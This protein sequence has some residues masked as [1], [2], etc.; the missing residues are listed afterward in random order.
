MSKP[1]IIFTDG[2][3][4]GNPGPGGWGAVLVSPLGKVK[5]LG[6]AEKQTTNNRMEMTAALEA[7]L[8]L[9]RVKSLS[10]KEIQLYTDSKYL[11]NGIT[12]WVHGWRKNGWKTADGK[13]VTNK[14]IWEKL[15][16]VTKHF[17][18]EWNYVP[19]HEGV[20]GNERCDRIAVAFSKGETPR[21]FNVDRADYPIHIEKI[22]RPADPNAKKTK[23]PAVYLSYVDGELRRDKDWKSC[24]A[25]VKGKQGA[26]FK[27]VES[28]EEESAILRSWGLK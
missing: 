17:K 23:M 19:G 3:C 18:V 6:G 25:R 21:L 2:A 14:D 9:T 27:K 16:E 7:L 1:V 13:D 12:A 28:E 10:T 8:A 4:S 24:E 22:P 20:P 11:I 5:E 15:L 26:K